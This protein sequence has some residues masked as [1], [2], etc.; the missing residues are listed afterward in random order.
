MAKTSADSIL[1]SIRRISP[2]TKI[3]DDISPELAYQVLQFHDTLGFTSIIPPTCDTKDFFS[4][5]ICGVLKPLSIVRG[6]VT[7]LLA[8]KPVIT[9]YFRGVHGGA[10][11]SVAEA[12][13]LACARTI[14]SEDKEI[15]LGEL[16]VSYLSSAPKDAEV[17][18]TSNIVRSGRN[19]T[20][21]AVD[22]KVKPTEK[23]VYTARATFYNMP[24]AK[25]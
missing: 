16:S 11:A 4:K 7:C 9:N 25:L 5:V 13:S 8:V 14:L 15:F 23:L 12:V 20:I 10:V 1:E 22:F 18:V 3:S 17:I 24:I 2:T 21:V 19:L 6:R